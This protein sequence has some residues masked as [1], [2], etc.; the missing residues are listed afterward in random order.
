VAT[1]PP[2][3]LMP[4]WKRYDDKRPRHEGSKPYRHQWEAFARQFR[5]VNPLCL[6]CLERGRT[7]ASEEVHHVVKVADDPSLMYDEGNLRALCKACHAV[8]TRKGE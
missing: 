3:R 1:D 4:G 2:R 7:Q 6:D 5:M 8:R